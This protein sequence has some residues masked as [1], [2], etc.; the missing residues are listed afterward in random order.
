MEQSTQNTTTE[1]LYK[2]LFDEKCRKYVEFVASD[3][4]RFQML[5]MSYNGNLRDYMEYRDYLQ[6]LYDAVNSYTVPT[7]SFNAQTAITALYEPKLADY[8][9]RLEE[10]EVAIE[11][12]KAEFE[13]E[14]NNLCEEERARVES[15]VSPLKEKYEELMSYK[16]RLS[17]VMERYG[18]S[19][20]DVKISPDI[21]RKEYEKLLEASLKTCREFDNDRNKLIELALFPLDEDDSLI[22]YSYA[23]FILVLGKLA[24][25]LIG[26]A[27]VYNMLKNTKTMYSKVDALRV[28]ESMMY[29]VDFDKFI[30]ESEQYIEPERDTTELDAE[31]NQMR[32][33]VKAEDPNVALAEE[34]KKYRTD[35]A[36]NY[37]SSKM[38]SLIKSARD[39]K[40]SILEMVGNKLAEVKKTCD[41]ILSKQVRFGDV[42]NPSAVLDTN[43]TIGYINKAIPVTMDFGLTNLNFIGTYCPEIINQIKV[44]YLNM[45]LNVRANKLDTK[46]FDPEYLG[47]SFSEFITADTKPYLSVEDK[48]IEAFCEDARKKA[49]ESVMEIKTDDILTYN[50]KNE[51]AGMITRTYYLYIILTGIGDKFTDNKAFMELLSYSASRGVFI[52]TVCGKKL[53]NTQN[54]EK[55]IKIKDGDFIQYDFELGARAIATFADALKNNKIKA[56]D[57]R[58]GY[59]LKYLPEDKWWKKS[60]IKDV[61]VRL[62]LMNGD[63]SKPGVLYFDDKNVHFL[64]GGATGA[65]KSVAIDCTM[66]SMIHEYAPDELQLVYIDL[67]NAEVAKYVKNG[68]CQIPHCLIAAGTTDGEYCLSLFEWA[69]DEMLRRMRV[70]KEYGVQK[71]EDLR[72]MYDD[73]TREDYNPVVH[74]PRTVILIDEFQVM[75]NTTVVPQKIITKITGKI[76]SLVKLA[77]AASMHLW[78]TSQEMSGTLSKN[79]LDNFSTRG[80]LRCSKDV[81]SQLIGNDA[82]GN[83][84][85]K[86]GWMYSNTS[87]GQDPNANILWKVPYGPIGDLMQGIQELRDKAEQEGKPLLNAKFFD[88]KQGRTKADLDEAYENFEGFK[89]PNFM[90]LGERTVYSTKPTPLNFRFMKDDKEN[91]YMIG[92]ERQD[93]LDLIGTILDNI[94]HKDGNAS[95][96]IN[97]AD[98]DTTYLLNLERYMPEGWEDFLSGSR[99]VKEILDDMNELVELR[100]ETGGTENPLY[101]ILCMWEK[102]EGVGVSENYRTTD[103]LCNVI[104]AMNDVNIHVVFA[105]RDKG[106]PNAIVNMCNHKICAKA[107]EKICNVIIDDTRPNTF[108]APQGNEA[109]FALYRYGSDVRKFKIYRHTLERELESREL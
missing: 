45:L 22:V 53:P 80:A 86:V 24:L 92:V 16:E 62:G 43:F 79:L 20:S 81:S 11:N 18:I 68:I 8:N 50:R 12:K 101:V 23:V 67:K 100:K 1:G 49:A 31:I 76:E 82:S 58:A 27:Y 88:E 28:A 63:P 61:N 89:D 44:L 78:F 39:K 94:G 91:L 102:M 74:I 6:E 57:Y 56:L 48:D 71:V 30:P 29:S 103:A 34:L 7:F 25:P 70:C 77:R 96:I 59:L 93:I 10:L 97:S 38:E 15:T 90:V 108:P 40:A 65:G 85:D 2:T 19:P 105:C 60:A 109:C 36:L 14:W 69:Y 35:A 104:R 41:D 107:D 9:I 64:L 13:E 3:M 99:P 47:Q 4:S 106:I 52:W 17:G 55:E 21:T 98:K 37:V 46:V 5:D 54:I 75:F 66:Q 95:A 33:D 83:I 42:S 26:I 32:E 87:A 72:K 51:E 73:P 84:K